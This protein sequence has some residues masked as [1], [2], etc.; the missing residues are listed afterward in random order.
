MP[1]FNPFRGAILKE[2]EIDFGYP[3]R[4][5]KQFTITDSDVTA[6]SIMGGLIEAK[7]S[8]KN[9][10]DEASMDSFDIDIQ[11]G[12]GSFIATINSLEGRVCDTYIM[13][14]EIQ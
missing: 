13:A 4:F 1:L 7:L 6:A 11:P 2:V 8:T 12:N 9:Q 3:P 14:Y 10:A 5:E